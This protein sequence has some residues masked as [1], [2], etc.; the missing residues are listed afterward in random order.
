MKCKWHGTATKLKHCKNTLD[1]DRWGTRKLGRPRLTRSVFKEVQKL[2]KLWREV[3]RTASDRNSW[4]DFVEATWSRRSKRNIIRKCFKRIYVSE[5]DSF[6]NV[7][8][9]LF[10]LCS[11]KL[12]CSNIYETFISTKSV[13]I[14]NRFRFSNGFIILKNQRVTLNPRILLKRLFIFSFSNTI[15]KLF[16]QTGHSDTPVNK[17]KANVV[18]FYTVR[19]AV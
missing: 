16:S 1:W 10:F 5:T 14:N 6:P 15:W 13:K 18:F 2:G 12:F 7:F 9:N 17:I 19:P 11:Q 4:K 3:K 8:I